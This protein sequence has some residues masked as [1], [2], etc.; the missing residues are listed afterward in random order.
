M[1]EDQIRWARCPSCQ[2]D[3][4]CEIRGTAEKT[5]Y[6]DRD[7]T[8]WFA[9]RWSILQCRGCDE[10]FI[11][12]IETSSEDGEDT[13]HPDG[14]YEFICTE[15]TTYWPTTPKRRMPILVI[16]ALNSASLETCLYELYGAVD[17]GLHVLTAIGIRTCIDAASSCLNIDAALTFEE[18]LAALVDGGFI[19]PEDRSMLG[20]VINAG[21]AAA[22]RGWEPSQSQIDA[23][24]DV[25]EHFLDK[26]FTQPLR[27]KKMQ[28]ELQSL[29]QAV[30]PKA[31]R[32]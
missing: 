1:A 5:E 20:T 6:A 25:L 13:E 31:K 16:D 12:T 3:T 19:Q 17:G 10:I 9:R 4:K 23:M 27:K 22:H 32:K 11:Q 21:S 28:E 24:M 30:P 8:V 2:K 26:A 7:G 18:K 14:T 29:G 15:H